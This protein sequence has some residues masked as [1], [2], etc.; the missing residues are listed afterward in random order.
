MFLTE[1]LAGKGLHRIGSKQSRNFVQIL[2]LTRYGIPLDSRIT[3]FLNA[4]L[5]PPNNVS[6]QVSA[7]RSLRITY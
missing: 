4:N 7:T 5:D 1:R 3:R 6:S 2:G